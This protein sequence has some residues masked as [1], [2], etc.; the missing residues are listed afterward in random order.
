M[1][2]PIFCKCFDYFR[3]V[4]GRYMIYLAPFALLV[5]QN[6]NMSIFPSGH[7]DDPARSMKILSNGFRTPLCWQNIEKFTPRPYSR[8]ILHGNKGPIWSISVAAVHRERKAAQKQI[9]LLRRCGILVNAEPDRRVRK[10][11]RTCSDR[12]CSAGVCSLQ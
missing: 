7:G 11:A 5:L 12:C 2:D 9:P 8:L 4:Y 10:H 3:Q 1:R 6:E